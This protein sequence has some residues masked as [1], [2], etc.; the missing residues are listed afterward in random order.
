MAADTAA[1]STSLIR[2]TDRPTPD[3]ASPT[4]SPFVKIVSACGGALITSLLVTPLDLIKTRLQ[5]QIDTRH[6]SFLKCC[7]THN[8]SVSCK[9]SRRK[10]CGLSVAKIE[11]GGEM[12]GTLDGLSKILRHE[13]V[14]SLW[15]GLSPTLVMSV[16][17]TVIYFIGY[18]YLRDNVRLHTT[19]PVLHEYAPL[20]SGATARAASAII[21]SP[22]ELFR[23]RLQSP[24]GHHF[25]F[26]G[27][28]G[29]VVAMVQGEGVL[30][31][32]RGVA[33][34]LWRD[35]PFSALYW[36]G[37]EKTK[38]LL[39]QRWRRE[40]ETRMFE[41]AFLS[42][43][44]SGSVAA[45]LTTPF[46]VVKTLR[47]VEQNGQLDLVGTP[48]RV[49][50]PRRTFKMMQWVVRE[51]GIRGLWAGLVPRVAKVAPACAVMIS[52]YEVGKEL[53][54]RNL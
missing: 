53:F 34:T 29:G 36:Y 18:D 39:E 49:R 24:Q 31:L 8:H 41:I 12:K 30:S 15:R 48:Q 4:V 47:Q 25:G 3:S 32:W 54:G 20:L 19:S 37:Y 46:D 13:G 10:L 43:A 51:R 45:T 28:L 38:Y 23:T 52:S 50:T 27:V 33:A 7:D 21:I 6:N 35:V 22:L 17:S 11:R 42:G 2:T 44:I 9:Q 14:S 1:T 16:P 5:S 26:R 40:G